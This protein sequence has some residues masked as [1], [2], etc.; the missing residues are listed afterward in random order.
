VA[1]QKHELEAVR[2]LVDA[3]LDGN[4]SHQQIL[5]SDAEVASI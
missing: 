1:G 4:A 5:V 3:V 2:N